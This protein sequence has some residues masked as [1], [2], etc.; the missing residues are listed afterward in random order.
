MK[1]LIS[2]VFIIPLF[3]F[4]QPKI[5]IISDDSDSLNMI[6]FVPFFVSHISSNQSKNS[7]YTFLAYGSDICL[8]YSNKLK[9]SSRILKIDGN[10]NSALSD[11]IDSLSVYPGM[12][13]I[14]NI[15]TYFSLV[16][17]YRI[18]KNFKIRFGKGTSFFGEGYRS[19]LMSNNHAPYPFFTLIT[20]FWKIK[21]YNH[22]TTFYDI[23]NS[24]IS[25]KKHAAF[26]YLDY[27]LN[28]RLTIG[29]L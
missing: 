27:S 25:Q 8:N 4:S 28:D 14:S 24:D 5:E 1:R 12:N 15:I 21:Y 19:M 6:S 10:Y 13:K 29:L 16:T 3:S 9:I 7:S 18:N 26:H 11:Y 23:Y 22:F 2:L 20:N 17:N